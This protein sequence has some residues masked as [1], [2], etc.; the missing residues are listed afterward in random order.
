MGLNLGMG[1]GTVTGNM[2]SKS[3]TK[4]VFYVEQHQMGNFS[5]AIVKGNSSC[6]ELIIGVGQRSLC[7]H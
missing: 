5:Q 3:V 1:Q 4:L 2:E 6:N 7:R